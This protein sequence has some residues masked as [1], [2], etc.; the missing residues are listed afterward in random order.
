ML[1]ILTTA[2]GGESEYRKV[3][4]EPR[5][6]TEPVATHDT[7]RPRMQVAV[8][9]MIS[10]RETFI[11]Y[12]E[13]VDYLLD[14]LGYD[15]ELVQRKTYEEVNALLAEGAIDLAFICTGPFVDG[16]GASSFEAIA[17]PIVRGEPFYRSY[18]IVH[19]ESAFQSLADLEG[20]D[21]AFTDPDSNTGS[22][23][24]RFWLNLMGTTPDI[25]FNNFTF[26]YSHDN[27]IMA[28]AKK[29]VDG[30]AVDGHMWDYYQQHN[31]YHTSQTRVIRV[32]EPF[33]SPPV[34]V[35]RRMDPELKSAL[36]QLILTMHEDPEGHRILSALSIDRFT[37]PESQWYDPVRE[38]LQRIG[39]T[40]VS[41]DGA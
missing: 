23:V 7:D 6:E 17:T 4:F 34:V 12:R 13:L 41:A 25:F 11:Y 3:A 30:A 29:L 37:A 24:P 40:R 31:A 27:S 8:A 38:M 15:A 35:S 14:R 22:F 2:C 32:S 16:Q 18:L 20:K 36:I 28:V 5:I 39:N 9:A 26:T 33:G 10:P 1:L 21:F 19:R